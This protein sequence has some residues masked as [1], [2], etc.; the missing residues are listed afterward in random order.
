MAS[1]SADVLDAA[2]REREV[3]LTTHGRKT[4]NPHRTVLWLDREAQGLRA[5]G[6]IVGVLHFICNLSQ[7]LGT[8][9][10][11]S[12][13][14]RVANDVRGVIIDRRHAGAQ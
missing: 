7:M 4:G 8:P 9:H 6:S 10:Q 3:A 1:F 12:L 11:K 14:R 5:H 13:W 2:A